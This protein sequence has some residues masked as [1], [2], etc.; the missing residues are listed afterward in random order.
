MKAASPPEYPRTREIYDLVIKSY[1]AYSEQDIETLKTLYPNTRDQMIFLEG[2]QMKIVGWD[3]FEA[4]F[5][6]FCS[7][8]ED[9]VCTPAADFQF[10]RPC[11]NAGFA[12]G[13]VVMVC[14]EKSSGFLIRWMD[15]TTICF[16]KEDGKWKMIHHH[17]S[18]PNSLAFIMEE[19]ETDHNG[20]GY[21]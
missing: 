19:P 17:D 9:L 2:P 6:Q 20:S 5:R 4:F 11:E 21:W 13:T 10:V 12:F 18:V 7:S 1:K 3:A 8:Y 15:R 14:R 16:A